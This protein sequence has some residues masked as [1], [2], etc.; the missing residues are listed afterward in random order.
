MRSTNMLAI[1]AAG[2]STASASSYTSE[3]TT[4][5]TSTYVVTVTLTQC[6]PSNPKCPNYTG[7]MSTATT[8]NAT[9]TSYFPLV[10]ST[11][12]YVPGYNTTSLVLAP[13]YPHA[14]STTPSSANPTQPPVDNGGPAV[15]VKPGLLVGVFCAGIALLA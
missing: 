11:S 3:L 5:A 4:T 9:T 15:L 6:N 13:T 12:T 2:L 1:L 7:T 8:S 14:T 10:N